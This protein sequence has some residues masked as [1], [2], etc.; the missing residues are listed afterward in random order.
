MWRGVHWDNVA[1]SLGET[2]GL[3]A[4]SDVNGVCKECLAANSYL[5]A[6]DLSIQSRS[7]EPKPR[8]QVLHST[9]SD[10]LSTQVGRQLNLCLE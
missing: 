2:V 6:L 5:V 1:L 3:D 4:S 8:A 9:Y 10:L 7:Q